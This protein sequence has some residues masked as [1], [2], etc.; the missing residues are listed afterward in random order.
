MRITTLVL[1][2]ACSIGCDL[3]GPSRTVTGVWTA[4]L[5]GHFSFAGMTLDQ[6]GD[7]VS[8]TACAVSEGVLLYRNTPV[9]GDHPNLQFTVATHDVRSCC[10]GLVGTRFSGRLESSG[11]II[12]TYGTGDVRFKR[13]EL[14][15]CP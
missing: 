6:N 1:L 9:T 8:G 3:T 11:D 2:A 5:P 12:G 13:A 4:T 15:I 14:S 10:V 7:E